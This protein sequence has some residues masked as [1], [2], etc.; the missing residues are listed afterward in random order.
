METISTLPSKRRV[1]RMTKRQVKKAHIGPY[2][3][4]A[5]RV[6]FE[7]TG[8]ITEDDCQNAHVFK[9]NS[10]WD[11]SDYLCEWFVDL[12]EKHHVY[13]YFTTTPIEENSLKYKAFIESDHFGLKGV[14]ELKV[15]AQAFAKEEKVKEV[16]VTF[17]DGY[18]SE[19]RDGEEIPVELFYEHPVAWLDDPSIDPDV[20]LRRGHENLEVF[21]KN[22]KRTPSWNRAQCQHLA[23]V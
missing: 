13:C 5:L 20:L 21:F 4:V 16:L 9:R 19:E 7:L 6:R 22:P 14:V 11:E 10:H 2:R 1:K 3:K 17:I 8:P 15:F 12:V 23:G 18:Y